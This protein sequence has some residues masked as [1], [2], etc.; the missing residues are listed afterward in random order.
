MKPPKPLLVVKL[1]KAFVKYKAV[2]DSNPSTASSSAASD[3]DVKVDPTTFSI[4]ES[5]VKPPQPA[6][7]PTQPPLSPTKKVEF[8]K[9]L[10]AATHNYHKFL[11]MATQTLSEREIGL[12]LPEIVTEIKNRKLRVCRLKY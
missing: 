3:G 10:R 6:A 9:K 5:D 7:K 8:E 11:K 12:C 1:E 2:R 4:T